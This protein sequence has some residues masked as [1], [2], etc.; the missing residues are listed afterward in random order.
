MSTLTRFGG[1]LTLLALLAGCVPAAPN[2]PP[3]LPLLEGRVEGFA[4]QT[5]ATTEEVANAATVSLI[6]PISG[7]TMATTVT[8]SDG[9]FTLSFSGGFLPG[10]NP[11]VLEAVKG[12]SQ[13]GSVNRAGAPAARL[14]TLIRHQNGAW[15]YLSAGGLVIGSSSTALCALAGLKNLNDAQN[16]ALLGTLHVGTPSTSGGITA[17]DTFDGTAD[18]AESEFHQAWDLVKKALSRDLDPI[19]SVFLRPAAGATSSVATGSVPGFDANLGIGMAQEG[20]AVSSVA[21]SSA[22]AGA[23]AVLYG[24]GFPSATSS[25]SIRLAGLDCA[26]SSIN[27]AGTAVTFVVPSGYVPGTYPLVVTFGPWSSATLAFLLQ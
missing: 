16:V 4:R 26:V 1:G 24:H 3:P 11:Y 7:N 20:W 18:V 27:A 12:L 13:G 23:T 9:R 17:P 21:P 6:N 10:S 25:L 15:S 8:S 19:G 22:A 5:Q 2:S 14:R